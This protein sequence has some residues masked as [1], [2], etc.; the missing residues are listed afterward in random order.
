[1]RYVV[2]NKDKAG[3]VHIPLAG[4]LT[5]GDEVM[6]NEKEVTVCNLLSG[7]LEERAE[8]IDGRV[9]EYIDARQLINEGGWA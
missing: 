9:L 7:T 5:K 6:L 3:N 8:Q 1:M 2:A 4:H